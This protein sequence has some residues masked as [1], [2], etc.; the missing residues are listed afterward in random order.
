MRPMTMILLLSLSLSACG[1]GD[2]D[3]NI[4]E[5]TTNINCNTNIYTV[6]TPADAIAATLAR[7]EES[8]ADVLRTDDLPS[9][10]IAITYSVEQCNGNGNIDQS[11]H[12]VG[13]THIEGAQR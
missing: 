1:L 8:G 10:E 3:R 6:A 13:D 5:N 9:G 2:G 4:V 12:E 11:D 7:L